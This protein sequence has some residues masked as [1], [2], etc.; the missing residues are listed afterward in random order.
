M[1]YAGVAYKLFHKVAR[2]YSYLFSDLKDVLKLAGLPYSVEEYFCIYLLTATIVGAVS[3]L[4]VF[5][6]LSLFFNFLISLV[7]AFLVTIPVMGALTLFFHVYPSH[8][9]AAKRKKIENILYFATVYMSTIAGTGAPPQTIFKVLAQFGEFGEI[10]KVA[11]MIVRDIEVLGMDI[12]DALEHAAE[13][14]PSEKLREL[15]WGM[16]STIT[17]GGDLKK[18]LDEKARGFAQAYKRRLEEF[19]HTLSLFLEIYITAVVVGSVFILVLTTIMSLIGGFTQQLQ[20]LQLLLILVGL[21]LITAIYIV[22]LKSMS[23][24]EV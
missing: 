6:I 4:S 7:G 10:S 20:T 8:L 17:S 15:L 14:C 11:N 12:T 1:S 19:T 16:R 23:P 22:M 3:F 18:F 13:R 21:P 24:T 5:L 9:N 2:K